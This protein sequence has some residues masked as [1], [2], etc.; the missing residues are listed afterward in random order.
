MKKVMHIF[1][2]IIPFYIMSNSTKLHI[3][4]VATMPTKVSLGFYTYYI[5]KDAK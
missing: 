2:K 4:V 1:M 5:I 3:A